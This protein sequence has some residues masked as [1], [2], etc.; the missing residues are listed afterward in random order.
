MTASH[1]KNALQAHKKRQI[2]SQTEDKETSRAFTVRIFQQTPVLVLTL[3][4]VV[5]L[6]VMEEVSSA[7]CFCTK[8]GG[9]WDMAP[10][11]GPANTDTRS[12]WA[13]GMAAALEAGSTLN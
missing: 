9:D 8:T 3:H 6:K 13:K 5:T 1:P 11:P 12:V 7:L 4:F 10:L 2:S